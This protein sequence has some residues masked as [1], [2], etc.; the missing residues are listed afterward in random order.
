MDTLNWDDILEDIEEQR[1]VLL[2]GHN[3]FP[4]AHGELNT[5]LSEKLKEKLLYFYNRDGLFL[6]KDSDAKT[7][8][9]QVTARF[10]KS[11]APDDDILKKVVEMPFRLMISANPDKF[12][13]NAF[14][15]YKQPLQFDYFSSNNKECEYK[16]ERPSGENPLLYNLCGSVEDQESLILDYDDLFKMLKT[17]LADLKVPN[18]IRLP[19][20]KTTT[21]IFVGFHFERWY[22]QLFLRYLNMN[23]NQ[24]S[25][26]SR[27]YVLKTTFKDTDMQQFF[28]EQ[29]NV[30]F[31]GADWLFFEQMHKRFAKK[32][33]NKLRKVVEQ[34]SPTAT[35]IS[36]L[37]AK[38]EY[39]SAFS[40]LKIFASQFDKDD[41]DMLTMAE[42]AFSQY[43]KDKAEGIVLTEHLN[44]ALARVRKNILD[45]AKK[46]S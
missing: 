29:F 9:Q 30:K 37:V 17:L 5:Q 36:Q 27:N 7:T 41:L 15:Q 1:A 24:F 28:M 21:Y 32:Y 14:A 40:M 19:L 12:L 25:N 26:N 44:S 38:S 35:T 20:M 23:D 45:L 4:N 42:S 6:F 13:V 33:P 16:I 34:L 39:A 46:L 11:N 31:I 18:E 10:Y 2:I 8:A 22:T 43:L 3:F